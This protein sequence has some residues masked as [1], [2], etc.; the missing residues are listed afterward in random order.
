MR[1]RH[2]LL[3]QMDARTE[4]ALEL[5]LSATIVW[6][7][8]NA[9][10]ALTPGE[11]ETAAFSR[12]S[13]LNIGAAAVGA[14]AGALSIALC[15]RLRGGRG[16]GE[17][18]RPSLA[19]LLLVLLG[20]LGGALSGLGSDLGLLLESCCQGV[21]PMQRLANGL[22]AITCA[23][24]LAA[25]R[26]LMLLRWRASA[27][28]LAAEALGDAAPE[29]GA[30]ASPAPEPPLPALSR[31]AVALWIT[32]ELALTYG[33][34]QT[35]ALGA[36]ICNDPLQSCGAIHHFWF[37]WLAFQAWPV[38]SAVAATMLLANQLGGRGGCAPGKGCCELRTARA[39][40]LCQILL[41]ALQLAIVAANSALGTSGAYES[42]AEL[43]AGPGLGALGLHATLALVRLSWAGQIVKAL[44]MV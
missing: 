34:V 3:N 4:L 20:L 5:V 31:L 1:N 29:S 12:R 42:G 15:W 35:N 30:A 26:P 24:A 7:S 11:A 22:C 21:R 6:S 33:A 19:V 27:A 8:A 9:N 36:V 14:L 32:A 23:V 38:G 41:A 16:A 13:R 40:A 18:P 17:T 28:A 39:I 10:V 43:Q 37:E 2:P 44:V 25:L